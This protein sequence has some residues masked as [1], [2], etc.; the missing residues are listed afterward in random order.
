MS[1]ELPTSMFWSVVL[2]G[3]TNFLIFL[4]FLLGFVDL[5]RILLSM[6]II[7]VLLVVLILVANKRI[8]SGKHEE[9]ESTTFSRKMFNIIAAV[10]VAFFMAVFGTWLCFF[11][12]TA[13][14]CAFGLHEV[15]LV[16]IKRKT[17]FTDA[18]NALGRQADPGRPYMASFLCLFS[19]FIILV[20]LL[21]FF[22]SVWQIVIIFLVITLTWGI[23]DTMAWYVGSN[24]GT[25]KLKLPFNEDKTA[26]G[27]LA[28]VAT[29]IG[30]AFLLFSPLFQFILLIPPLLNGVWYIL[31]SIFTGFIGAFFEALAR[32]PYLDD[33]LITPIGLG[34]IL[35][36]LVF[37]L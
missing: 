14:A 4:G 5:I 20:F 34:I 26:E 21:V 19:F 27:S 35:T 9:K 10:V 36:F 16:G 22:T 29:G 8:E 32:S 6:V 28:F 12:V 30:L 1:D 33:N 3:A 11:I 15:I 37:F 13:L 7:D 2:I 18:F 31:V 25:H 17:H 23:G 24:W